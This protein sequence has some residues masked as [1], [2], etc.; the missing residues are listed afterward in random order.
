MAP[1]L[2]Q[3]QSNPW[4]TEVLRYLFTS[5]AEKLGFPNLLLALLEFGVGILLLFH[6]IT[7]HLFLEAVNV[8][9]SRA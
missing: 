6:P 8:R 7:I 5:V 9:G 3:L 1:S 2:R 4:S